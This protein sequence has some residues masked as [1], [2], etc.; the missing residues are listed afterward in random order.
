[1]AGEGRTIGDLRVFK[2]IRVIRDFKV[3]RD[4][5]DPIALIVF[6]S[7]YSAALKL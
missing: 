6:Q 5:R 1:M 2:V 4:L 7:D 3:L